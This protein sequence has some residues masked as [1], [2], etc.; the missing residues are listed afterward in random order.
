LY[1]RNPRTNRRLSSY[2]LA[3]SRNLTF[4][5]TLFSENLCDISETLRLSREIFERCI[6]VNC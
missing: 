1:R 6:K 5:T 4:D 2:W 3:A